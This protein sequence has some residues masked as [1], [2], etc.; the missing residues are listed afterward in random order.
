MSHQKQVAESIGKSF[1]PTL[2]YERGKPIKPLKIPDS[3]T[4]KS[5]DKNQKFHLGGKHEENVD[6]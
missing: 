1:L 5:R 3:L 4:G 6:W 2:K